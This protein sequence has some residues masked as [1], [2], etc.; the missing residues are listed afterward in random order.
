MA[1]GRKSVHFIL[2]IYNYLIGRF[3]EALQKALRMVDETCLGFDP[4]YLEVKDDVSDLFDILISWCLNDRMDKLLGK[5]NS[6][7]MD[8]QVI[9]IV[10][11]WMEK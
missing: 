7:Q 1:V 9:K 4:E 10:G 5:L 6:G 3:E 2:H 8:G 11:R